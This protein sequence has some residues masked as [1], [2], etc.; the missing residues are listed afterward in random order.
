ME[1]K[2]RRDVPFEFKKLCLDIGFLYLDK[3]LW[4]KGNEQNIN[5]SGSGWG[6]YLS[7]SGPATP[8]STSSGPNAAKKI[9]FTR[10]IFQGMLPTVKFNCPFHPSAALWCIG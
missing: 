2:P 1:K 10:K 4:I 8:R 3:I 5:V 9:A 6:T 7:P